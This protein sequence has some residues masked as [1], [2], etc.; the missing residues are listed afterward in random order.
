MYRSLDQKGSDVS[1]QKL[2]PALK[3]ALIAYSSVLTG[4]YNRMVF[5]RN[6]AAES[7]MRSL[8]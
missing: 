8:P 7:T 3:K 6:Y 1:W 5:W 4:R 2:Y